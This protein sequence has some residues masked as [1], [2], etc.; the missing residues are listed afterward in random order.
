MATVVSLEG[1]RRPS[2][3]PLLALCDEDIARVER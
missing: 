1:K 3:E 2:L